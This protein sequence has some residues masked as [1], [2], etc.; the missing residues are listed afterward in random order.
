MNNI[1]YNEEEYSK[2]LYKATKKTR[3][4]TSLVGA[5]FLGLLSFI[6]INEISEKIV[7]SII[8][9]IFIFIIF[10]AFLIVILYKMIKSNNNLDKVEQIINDDEIIETVYL[11]NGK[12]NESIYKYSD[13]LKVKEDNSNYYLY[14]AVNCII[15]ISKNKI[16]DMDKFAEILSLLKK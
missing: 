10:Y 8:I 5:L 4:I 9:S 6:L 11:K 7:I 3:F 1:V 15:A 14:I 13:V 2:L 16:K 12:F